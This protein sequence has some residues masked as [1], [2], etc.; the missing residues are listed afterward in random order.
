MTSKLQVLKA[1]TQQ[2]EKIIT[3][4]RARHELEAKKLHDEKAALESKLSREP[5]TA[6]QIHNF[7]Q[8][9]LETIL[10]EKISTLQAHVQELETNFVKEREE[11]LRAQARDQHAKIKDLK[12]K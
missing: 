7:Y 6:N 2:Y 10:S 8:S 5:S 9:Q 1:A 3:D 4:E 11:S 12:E